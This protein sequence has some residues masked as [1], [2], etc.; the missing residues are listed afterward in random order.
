MLLKK[1]GAFSLGPIVSAFLGFITVPLITHFISPEEYGK[2]SMFTLA[3]GIVSMLVY[4]GM[5]QAFVREFNDYRDRMSRLL[6]NAVAIP[7]GMS[8]LISGLICVFRRQ[9]GVFLFDT[10]AELTAV[11]M[12]AAL[13]PFMVLE[14]FALLK[15]RMEE[16]GVQYSFF[17][18]LLKALI[19]AFT[20]GLFFAYE[21]SF[22]SVVFAM[23][24]GEICNSVILILVSAKSLKLRRADFDR[25]LVKRMIL[26]GLPLIP[27]MM[28]NWILSSMDKLMIRFMC[29]Y[30]E[31]GLYEAAFKIVNAL[32]IVQSC[33]TLFWTPV[34]Y[35]WYEEKTEKRNFN[36]VNTAVAIIMSGMCLLLLIAKE[37]VGVVLGEEFVEAIRIFP[38]LLLHPIMY[39]MSESTAV[40][41]GF[42]RK[43][44]YSIW[45][46][47]VGCVVNLVLN[48]V[49][50]P[51]Y[52][53]TG[54]AIATG[55]SFLA[56]FWAR[57][58]ASRRCWWKFDMG[59][60]YPIILILLANCFAHTFLDNGISYAVSGVSLVL[61]PLINRGRIRELIRF[62]KKN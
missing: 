9:V 48:Y 59:I 38:F 24:I 33:F 44:Y 6:L 53:A 46:S 2:A 39:T 1:L 4:L 22:R 58:L 28:M 14:N 50:I 20:V 60:Y 56:F 19:L 52:G 40:G 16:K 42:S 35:R 7:L 61:I 54:A 13:I 27:A 17:T 41:I 18:I 34:A 8:C 23:A 51:I 3:Q 47:A 37:L 31:L 10:D 43:T 57:T 30:E 5:D 36:Y 21:R 45:V 29:G 26:F 49:L 55:L 62:C 11:Y 25:Q 32:A 12:F 15:I